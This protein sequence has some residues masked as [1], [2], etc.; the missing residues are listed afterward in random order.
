MPH[1]RL[2]RRTFLALAGTSVAASVLAPRAA[3]QPRALGTV[4][5]YS[6]GVPSGRSVRAA[7][8]LGA[9]RYVSHP[10]PGAD[11]MRGKPLRPAE[12]A[13]FRAN[14]LATASVYQFGKGATADWLAGAAG[15][16]TH[17]PQAIALHRAAGG[18]TGRPI[19][20]AIDDNPSRAQYDAQIRPYLRAFS[21]TLA[22]A[23]Y[24]TGVYGNYNVIHWCVEDGIGTYFWMHDWGSGGRI[25]PRA[26]LH[27]PSGQTTVIDGVECD[28]NTVFAADW[29]QWAPSPTLSPS[30]AP[31]P[32]APLQQAVQTSSQLSS[33]LPVEQMLRA[34][35]GR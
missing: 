9:V 23:G 11:W 35:L 7:G 32:A 14:G 24:Q 19:Y 8:H 26:H 30:P 31:A 18:P 6:A 1:R 13:D 15:A 2:S 28:V 12:A 4:L 25:H 33:Q 16:A 22:A 20:V 29:G 10:R 3:A 17:A 21:A 34:A 27:Q 5:D